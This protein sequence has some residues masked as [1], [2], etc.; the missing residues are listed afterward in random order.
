[1]K[2]YPP[3]AVTP[4][5]AKLLLERIEPLVMYTSGD[6]TIQWSINGGLAP[7]P[8]I[9]EGAFLIDGVKGLHPPFTFVEYKGARQHGVTVQHTVFDPAEYDMQVEFT[10][11]PNHVNPH[12]AAA[13]IRRVIR[14]W[15]AS[16][17]P[18]TPGTLVWVTPDQ[19]R[20]YCHPRLFKS[21]PES[22]FR[23]QARRLRQKYTWTI[24]ND[25]A[26]WKGVDSVSDFRFK[27][28]L[29]R[30]TFNID[31]VGT[32]GPQWQ[33]TYTGGF[34]RVNPTN[35][36]LT[37]TGGTPTVTT[38][39]TGSQLVI[40]TRA[41]LTLTGSK[42]EI[43]GVSQKLLPISSVLALIG[44]VP[45]VAVTP[46]GN[47]VCETDPKGFASWTPSGIGE[48]TVVNRLLGV[49]EIQTV[50]IN[51]VFT[52][53]TWTY[54]V[55]G[56]T[57]TVANG[58]SAATF[59]TTLEALSNVAPGDVTVTGPNGGPY[60]LTYKAALGF[61]NIT[62]S[63]SGAGL[64]PGGT[65]AAVT[66]GTTVDGV[67]P[68]TATDNQI[69]TLAIGDAY[70]FPFPTG[71]YLDLWGRLD[72][73]D[74]SPT[75]IRARIGGGLITLSRFNAGVE[76]VMKQ[77][78]L[79]IS[80]AWWEDWRLYC[81]TATDARRFKVQRQNFTRM[82]FKET[83]TGSA[84][85]A[86]NRGSGW[87]MK[88]GVPGLFTTVA[89]QVPPS[90]DEFSVGDNV[91]VTQAGHLNL[92]NFGDQEGSPRYLVYGPGT[93]KIAN[94]P[95]GPMV[96]FG[97]LVDNQVALLTT[98]PR[99]RGVVD[100]S[101]DLPEQDLDGFQEFVKS[102]LSLAV[103]NNT[104][105]LLE[106]FESLL[107]IRPPQGELYSLLKGRFSKA[108]PPKPAGTPPVTASIPVEIVG[109]NADSKVIAALTPLRRW[110][111]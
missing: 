18:D 99:L 75:G 12:L 77:E 23:E 65:A 74:A 79:F 100:L 15:I 104:P 95:G 28:T 76:T 14:E 83:G 64:T 10:V 41:T 9:Q 46:V 60:V 84:L 13:A 93:F 27:Y 5:G 36:S 91:T 71:G 67:G 26:F 34:Q 44:S 78:I 55:N 4:Y 24:R 111:E 92:T 102:L 11:P 88:V 7:W 73:N 85:G 58:A 38:T 68:N 87:G 39:K 6:E 90:V 32:L 82:D 16:W 89:Q 40:P 96:E 49:N 33:Q 25:D 48:R 51:G 50:S 45:S 8:G 31:Y 62:S 108:I 103:G 70:Q 37:I 30:D 105:P 47:G 110:P 101:P 1:M 43:R 61:Q 54:T 20:W 42:P 86:S 80:P 19:G 57:A 97:P 66:V 107:G 56:Q 63:A 106:W 59:Q 17:E 72:S 52:G 29:A 98:I 21:P 3:G 22:Q 69:I 81:G 2:F 109:G 94:G 35:A 53:G